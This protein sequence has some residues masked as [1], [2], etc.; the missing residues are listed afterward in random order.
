MHG[1]KSGKEG[2]R[3]DSGCYKPVLDNAWLDVGR[4]DEGTAIGPVKGQASAH[5]Q[6]AAC[7][8]RCILGGSDDMIVISL[9]LGWGRPAP[10]LDA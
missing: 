2:L 10:L 5:P 8:T 1:N 7:R 3:L 9:K 6:L 4:L